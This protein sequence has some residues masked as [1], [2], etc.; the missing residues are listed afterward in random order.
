MD[1]DKPAQKVDDAPTVHSAKCDECKEQI[2]GIRYKCDFCPDYDLCSACYEKNPHPIEHT[3][4]EHI[5][6]IHVERPPLTPEEEKRQKE[7]IAKKLEEMRKKKRE[8][9]IAMEKE[10]EVNR[11]KSGK[12]MVEAKKK[13]GRRASQKNC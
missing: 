13:M 11:R 9:E 12:D 4:T 1:V 2:I 8:D 3:F 7:L 10:R 5:K 6:D